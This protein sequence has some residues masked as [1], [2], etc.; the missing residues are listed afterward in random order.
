MMR[1][2]VMAY[3]T[4][5]GVGTSSAVGDALTHHEGLCSILEGN[6]ARARGQKVEGRLVPIEE[7]APGDNQRSH[8]VGGWRGGCWFGSC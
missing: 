8:R 6:V 7:A 4:Q 3:N 5:D 1:G 2:I